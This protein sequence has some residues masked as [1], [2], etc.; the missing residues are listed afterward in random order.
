MKAITVSAEPPFHMRWEEHPTPT[1]GQGEVRISVHA[2]AVNRADLLQR[3]GKYPPP[4]GASTILGL[5]VSGRIDAVGPGVTNYSVGQPV[6]ALL[7]GGGYAEKVV[8][9]EELLLPIPRGLSVIQ[10][11]ALP[12]V[13]TTA[14]LN[15]WEEARLQPGQRV[16][17]HAGGSGV[18]TMAVQLC[19]A[20][21]NPVW[22]TAGTDQ[23][24]ARCI[25]LGA[26]AGANRHTES[27]AQK[28]RDWTEGNG[29]DVILD[30][31][32]SNY[33]QDNLKSLAIGGRLVIIGLLGG[34]QGTVDLGRL[35]VKRQTIIGSV[36]RSRSNHEKGTIL[37]RIRTRVW[38]EIERGA[39]QPIMDSVIP[40]E[41][42]GK[43]HERVAANKTLGKVI[44]TLPAPS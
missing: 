43:A 37:S 18:G 28:A 19:A 15:L 20:F 11:A 2:T 9:A 38:P 8:V 26:Q 21:G 33:L 24:I 44:L 25:E 12:E 23:K 5:E 17:V 22:V 34:R 42:V 13:V 14:W 32:G 35:M 31:V 36:L 16:L 40:I 41:Q 6:C 39:V 1:P 27:F 10:A 30:P 3:Q 29:F 4:P 7:S